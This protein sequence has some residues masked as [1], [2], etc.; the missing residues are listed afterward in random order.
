MVSLVASVPAGTSNTQAQAV[1]NSQF[2]VQEINQ[3]SKEA[4]SS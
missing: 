2:V 3:P 4:G 1:P